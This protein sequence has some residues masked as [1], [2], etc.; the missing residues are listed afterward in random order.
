MIEY[1]FNVVK[2]GSMKRI[3]VFDIGKT[4]IKLV[5]MDQEFNVLA[6]RADKNQVQDDGAYP[7]ADVDAIWDWFVSTT[8]EFS[9]DYDIGKISITTHGATAALIRDKS[10]ELVLP[11]MDYEFDGL[12]S[13]SRFNDEYQFNRPPFRKSFSPLLPAGLNLA[14]QLYWQ[15]KFFPEEFAAADTILMYP[16]FWLWKL[17]SKV[18]SEVTSLGCHTDLWQPVAQEWSNLVTEQKWQSKFPTIVPAWQ[19]VGT[20]TAEVAELTGL[21]KD[22]EVVAGI[23]DSNASFVRHKLANGD[24]PFTIISTGTWSIVMASGVKLSALNED[25]DMLANVDLTNKPIA[26]ARFMGGREYESIC[27][28]TESPLDVAID[29]QSVNALAQHYLDQTIMAIPSFSHEGGPF[30][31]QAGKIIGEV[32]AGKGAVL[33]S[34]YCALMLDLQLNNL[35]CKGDIVIEGA[36]IKNALIC[37]LLAQLRGHQTVY[38]SQDN[39]GTVQGAAQLTQWHEL[40]Q[41][42][43][44]KVACVKSEFTG[45]EDYKA[46]WLA[47]T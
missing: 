17:T 26:C 5:V 45:L 30:K 34:I 33:A 13:D 41:Q 15:Q 4:H 25:D 7:H 19:T 40:Q 35:G 10:S 44:E 14:K 27:A 6:S 39:T 31:H 29:N 11:V 16:Q 28:L 24:A 18:C 37:Q 43:I 9:S 23:H 47:H 21:S 3:L 2:V 20:V 1:D 42:P 32:E 12:D 8:R 36:F 22:C 46:Q 38:I